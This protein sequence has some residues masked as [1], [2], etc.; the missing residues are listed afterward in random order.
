M[1]QD[2]QHPAE[3]TVGSDSSA[4]LA[5]TKRKG[6]GKVRHISLRYL[7]VQKKLVDEEFDLEQTRDRCFLLQALLEKIPL[8]FLFI[9][10]PSCS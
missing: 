7:W 4:T 1:S 5:M 6:L 8:L 9:I 2:L 3:L 10:F